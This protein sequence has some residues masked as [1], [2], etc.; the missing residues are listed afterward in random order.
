MSLFITI[1]DVTLWE[2]EMSELIVD[3]RRKS[4]SCGNK[5]IGYPLYKKGGYPW[6]NTR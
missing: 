2:V 1:I 4:R 5:K 3:F 6:K